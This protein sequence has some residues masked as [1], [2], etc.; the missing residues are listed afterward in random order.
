MFSPFLLAS[1]LLVYTLKVIIPFYT[2]GITKSL[3]ARPVMAELSRVIHQLF[4]GTRLE[5]FV[6]EQICEYPGDL[7]TSTASEIIDALKKFSLSEMY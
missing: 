5:S 4:N 6:S 2:C 3:K 1:A 7:E